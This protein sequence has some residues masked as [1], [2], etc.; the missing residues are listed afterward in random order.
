MSV[1]ARQDSVRD[2]WTDV[3]VSDVVL[4]NPREPALSSDAPFIPMEAIEPDARWVTPTQTRGNR[5]GARLAGGDVLFARITPCLENGKVGQYR[6]GLPRAGGSTE[7]IVLRATAAID[8]SFLYFWA[9]S[10]HTRDAATQ[11]MVGSTGRQRLAA[12]DLAAMPLS[13]PSL[14]E[15]RRIADCLEHLD[16]TLQALVSVMS[17]TGRFLNAARDSLLAELPIAPL[18]DF[19]DGIDAGRSPRCEERPPADHEIGVLKVSAV[20]FNEFEA[21]ESKTLLKG[22]PYSPAHLVSKGDILM[23]RANGSLHLVGAAC[24][25]DYQ[26]N[27]L[28]LC[29]KTLRLRP[30]EADLD[31]EY[32]LHVLL[33]ASARAQIERDAT[34]SSGQKNI[35]QAQIRALALPMPHVAKQQQIARTLQ[36]VAEEER[37][38]AEQIS[39]LRRMREG[40]IAQLVSGARELPDSYDRFLRE[41]GQ[42]TGPEA[43]TV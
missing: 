8:P 35:S 32:L 21:R 19:L 30:R 26:R 22:T 4:V 37:R 28:L 1:F 3:V 27:N 34:G 38:R 13:L 15:Q 42:A 18:G 25:V 16:D 14:P 43:A 41:I 20:R 31:P 12:S 24:R 7:L 6:I 36:A 29:D 40:L 11:L 5:S 17:Q 2:S 33:S 10:P 39:A 23:T 9:I